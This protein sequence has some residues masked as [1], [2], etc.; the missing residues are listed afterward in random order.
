MEVGELEKFQICCWE[1]GM[2]DYLL[3]HSLSK[4]VRGGIGKERI[5]G[6]KRE[7]E[8]N[9]ERGERSSK[10]EKNVKER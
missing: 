4:G 10:R 1:V 9:V 5:L 2:R 7:G 6:V 8:A 3:V